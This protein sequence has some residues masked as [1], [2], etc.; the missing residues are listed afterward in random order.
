MT[1]IPEELERVVRGLFP[2]ETKL[3]SSYCILCAMNWECVCSNT[4]RH[5][6]TV[7][8]FSFI[9]HKMVH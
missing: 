2:T 7:L 6:P 9:T 8:L 1:V 4:D 5:K 3:S